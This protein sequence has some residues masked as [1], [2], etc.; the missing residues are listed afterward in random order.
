MLA[1]KFKYKTLPHLSDTL[2]QN[3]RTNSESLCGV[4][5]ARE[6]MN[7][8]VAISSV[9]QADE[10]TNIELVKFP[11]RS[12]LL[13]R[14]G[15]PAAGPGS[16]PLRLLKMIAAGFKNPW[17]TLK[18]LFSRDLAQNGIVLLVMQTLDNSMRMIWKNGRM[19]MDN[20]AEEY[21]RVPAY[22]AA[23]QEVMHRFADKTGGVAVNS[24]TE[25]GL[26]MASTAHIIGGCPMGRDAA[27]GVVDERFAVHNYPNMY[28]VDGSVIPCN[29]GVNPSLTITALAEW[30]MEHVQVRDE[31]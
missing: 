9:F 12:G 29:P 4:T 3:L 7:H 22:I 13:M 23:G 19:K 24:I 2:G 10:H 27:G 15:A 16:I 25:I 30:A 5:N 8:G 6:K 21:R 1:Q 20:T 31:R 28:I 14:L 18:V 26:N 11:N 17:K